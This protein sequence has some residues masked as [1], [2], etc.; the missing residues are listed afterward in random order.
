MSRGGRALSAQSRSRGS[1]SCG[2]IVAFF[3]F[4]SEKWC[5]VRGEGEG[6]WGVHQIWSHEGLGANIAAGTERKGERRA[7]DD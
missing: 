5:D 1:I 6:G 4:F 3:F 7:S 2:G